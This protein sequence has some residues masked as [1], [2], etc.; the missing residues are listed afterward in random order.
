MEKQISQI[1]FPSKSNVFAQFRDLN[2][3]AVG[4]ARSSSGIIHQNSPLRCFSHELNFKEFLISTKD[5][6]N[7]FLCFVI[8]TIFKSSNGKHRK[9]IQR[10]SREAFVETP[11][12]HAQFMQSSAES[13][14]HPQDLSSSPH[15]IEN[16]IKAKNLSKPFVNHF[17]KN[18]RIL[19]VFFITGFRKKTRRL[20]AKSNPRRLINC[21]SVY[22]FPI[23]KYFYQ[24]R[25]KFPLISWAFMC[26]HF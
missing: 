15:F 2:A 23:T 20:A 19:S 16:K 11:P 18:S 24:F 7:R 25:D 1:I 12:A 14:F 4:A 10:S 6:E 8:F 17:S 21:R 5:L 26:R 13:L 22:R 9:I 3:K